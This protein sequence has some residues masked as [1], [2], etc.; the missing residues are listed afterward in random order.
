MKKKEIILN[1]SKGFIIGASM[2]V[3]GVSGG[4]MAI[5][6]GI[7]DKLI[8]AINNFFKDFKNS[9]IFLA[10]FCLGA[11]IGIFALSKVIIFAL[12]KFHFPVVYFF[13][14]V[15][16]GGVPL[17]L[18]QTKIQKA[19][20]KGFIIAIIS[21]I[22][23][24]ALVLSLSLIPKISVVFGGG[25]SFKAI[26]MQLILGIIIAVALVLPGISTT[27]MLLILGMYETTTN[28]I[29]HP[30]ENLSFLVSL[31]VFVVIGV[32]LTTNILEKAMTKFPQITYFAIIGFVLGSILDILNELTK[33]RKDI[34]ISNKFD[35]SLGFP[36][37][38]EIPV[39]IV[40]LV[41]GYIAIRYISKFS[42]DN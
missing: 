9:F 20:K 35:I 26:I 41:A 11:G 13:I 23:G 2:L 5:I 21:G 12:D 15:I 19:D 7:Y 10:E 42:N 14:G 28:A 33:Y 32:F 6:F 25:F 16:L 39:C 18:K 34:E 1:T 37:G 31:A 27:H 4:T 38:W 30:F 29:S 17:L 3:P 22:L 8:H 40:T 36:T 24:F